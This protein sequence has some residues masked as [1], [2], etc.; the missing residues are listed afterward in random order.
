MTPANFD[1][2]LSLILIY[3]VD[4]D[5][6]DTMVAATAALD[7]V[8]LAL[9][10]DQLNHVQI[11]KLRSV[12]H[13]LTVGPGERKDGNPQ[14]R[15][16]P[17]TDPII[18]K[19]KQLASVLD[20][21]SHRVFALGSSSHPSAN[22]DLAATRIQR[23]WRGF[24]ARASTGYPRRQTLNYTLFN[25]AKSYVDRPLTH[26]PKA[27]IGVTPCYL[28]KELPL[29]LKQS[30]SPQN[31][32]RYSQMQ[33]ARSVCEANGYKHLVIPRARVYQ[34]FI[35]ESRLPLAD[36]SVKQ[37]IGLYTENR[38][39]FTAAVREMSGFLFHVD[40]GDLTGGGRDP[41][42]R[43]SHTQIGRYDNLPL[44]LEGGQGKIGLIDLE[45]LRSSCSTGTKDWSFRKCQTLLCFFPHH[46][47]EILEVAITF[48]PGIET[49]R[50]A[51]EKE[52]DGALQRFKLVHDDHLAFVRE[53]NITLAKPL[54]LP[55]IN[56]SVMEALTRD[57][58]SVLQQ[59]HSDPVFAG[60]LGDNPAE[61]MA[62]FE[63]ALPRIL[64]LV[65]NFLSAE[66]QRKM[67]SNTK[68][69]SY[70][71]LLSC[72][73]VLMSTENVFFE[74]LVVSVAAELKMMKIERSEEAAETGKMGY[75]ETEFA[76]MIIKNIFNGLAKSGQIAYFH[77]SLNG[78]L[79]VFF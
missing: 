43:L 75:I 9:N 29:V 70:S 44:Y 65:N 73:T 1:G 10:K 45:Q 53:K 61:V 34:N 25:R 47:N 60:C 58:M 50:A 77:P 18:Q 27:S 24:S 2:D 54:E 32:T 36:Y 55:A 57:M 62:L 40:L 66:M 23:L 49:H 15:I 41:Y 52:R 67:G 72:R 26:V 37:Q 12:L 56:A 51:L 69:T 19:A 3:A 11:E 4:S 39:Q 46:F 68:V 5:K 30:G 76:L 13:D 28:P 59:E 17:A 74:P 79:C 14:V 35:V 22:A 21:L 16:H 38:E 7:R 6:S 20:N 31:Q 33:C 64:N 63:K 71:Q 48:D 42:S 78:Q 8:T